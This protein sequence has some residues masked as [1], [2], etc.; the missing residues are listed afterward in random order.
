MLVNLHLPV[1]IWRFLYNV[2]FND[3]N[4]A[5]PCNGTA[6]TGEQIREKC[7]EDMP[8]NESYENLSAYLIFRLLTY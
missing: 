8:E 1:N 2:F 4:D 5:I 7:M 3:F 6:D